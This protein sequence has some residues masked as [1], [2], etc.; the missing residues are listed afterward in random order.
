MN[1]PSTLGT[2]RILVSCPVRIVRPR[3]NM[4]PT[5]TDVGMNRATNPTFA[6]P[7]M[8]NV[9]PTRIAS[10]ADSEP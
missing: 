6:R 10:A 7:R 9:T 8:T 3:P 2:P 5:W 1:D 4:K